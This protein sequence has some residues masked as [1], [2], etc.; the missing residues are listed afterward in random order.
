M[1][2]THVGLC[3]LLASWTLGSPAHAL[4]QI[5]RPYSGIRSSAM[6]GCRISTGLYDENF[7]GNPARAAD[8]PEWR[9]Q[10][11]DV[12][13]QTS[14]TTLQ[15]LNDLTGG[16]DILSR[17]GDTAGKNSHGRVQ[18]VFPAVYIPRAFG[19]K[20]A[21]AVGLI[22][23]T[24]ADVTLRR[25]YQIDPGTLTDLGPA[26]TVAR[27]FLENEVLTVGMTAHATYRLASKQGY[28]LVD[29]V[30]GVSFS[31]ASTGGDGAQVDFDLGT[32]WLLHWQPKGWKFT[33]ALALNNLLGGRYSNL[34]VHVLDTGLAPP[35][36]PR[37]LGM[38]ISARKEA[39]GPFRYGVF[40][41][42]LTDIGNNAG[43]SLFR[44]VH[45]GGEVR[46]GVLSPRLGINQG[47]LSGG[48]GLDLKA[49][50]IELATTGEEMSLN[51]G[52]IED[53]RYAIRIGFKI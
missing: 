18:T 25:S 30:Q 24:Q 19:G 39:L 48:L 23:S 11:L 10:I 45:L 15:N 14:T 20:W 21:W 9:F 37:T 22:S 33:P 53:R 3:V 35:T 36:Q 7:F 46:Y 49:L 44:L 51:P 52:G 42:E 32:T 6:G 31:P 26:F 38:G 5:I 34:P 29:L 8:N 4:E 12:Q 41:L 43:G 16:G 13:T 27:R 50:E 2:K 1:K 28:S 40:A 17:I 47:Y